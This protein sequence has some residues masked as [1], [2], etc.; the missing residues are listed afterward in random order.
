MKLH[1][2][3]QVILT[4]FDSVLASDGK[5]VTLRDKVFSFP[6]KSETL[7]SDLHGFSSSF[8]QENHAKICTK[9]QEICQR[10]KKRKKSED[11]RKMA[12]KGVESPMVAGNPGNPGCQIFAENPFLGP[13]SLFELFGLCDFPNIWF[14]VLKIRRSST[15]SLIRRRNHGVHHRRLQNCQPAN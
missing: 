14:S 11:G 4:S 1:L 2:K 5:S 9:Y 12:T 3:F 15:T 10:S 8:L 7:P 6:K 13:F